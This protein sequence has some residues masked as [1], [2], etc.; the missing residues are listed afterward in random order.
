MSRNSFNRKEIKR[1]QTKDN[2]LNFFTASQLKKSGSISRGITIGNNQDASVNSD[3]NLQLSGNLTNEISVYANITDNNIPI[4]ADGTSQ[5]LR[6]FDKVFIQLSSKS[7]ELIVGDFVIKKPIGSFMNFNKKVQGVGFSTNIET[8]KGIK[9]KSSVNTAI[10]KGKFNRQLIQ[11]IEGNQGPYKLS[12][13]NNELFVIILSGSEKVFIDGILQIRGTINDYIIDYNSAEVTFT[14]NKPITKDSRIIIEFEYSEMSYAKFA[15][16]SENIISTKNSVFYLNLFSENDA[17]NQS[18]RQELTDSNKLLFNQIGDNIDQ[19]LVTNVQLIDTFSR[20][21]I[22]YYETDTI[23][24][25]IQY[26]GVYV[27]STDSLK[28]NYRLGFSYVGGNSGNYIR[29]QSGA[30]GRIFEWVAPQEGILQAILRRHAKP[31]TTEGRRD[32]HLEPHRSSL[33][34]RRG[35]PRIHHCPLPLTRINHHRRRSIQDESVFCRC[36]LGYSFFVV[37]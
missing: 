23:V 3:F 2:E 34:R 12:G 22:L 33:A 21:D 10:S 27:Y 30:N 29:I 18:L 15:L 19:A 5:H 11:G 31:D 17:K 4:Q 1:Y 35:R 28:A 14:P 7:S 32:G 36:G 37:S 16:S 6:E 25:N 24:N 13:A 20:D 8:D 9:F 26:A